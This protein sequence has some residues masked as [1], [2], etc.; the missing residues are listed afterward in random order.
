MSNQQ[1]QIRANVQGSYNNNLSPEAR[2]VMELSAEKLEELL[3]SPI[4]F[5]H[6]VDHLD[7]V[8]NSR[9]LK[10]EW[11]LGNDN[12]SRKFHQDVSFFAR[13]LDFMR[14]PSYRLSFAWSLTTMI[15]L[16]C[17]GRNLAL[18]EVML[19]L[20]KSTAEGHKVAMELQ[21]S[22]EEKLQQ[23]QD[24]LW[25]NGRLNLRARAYTLNLTLWDVPCFFYTGML[26]A[27]LYVCVS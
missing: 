12:V 10:R 1:A 17:L 5:E 4:A 8:V 23:Q 24:A 27:Y 11:W 20:Q 2:I 7:I 6:F 21:K 25:V 18:E 3:E 26:I 19:E 16:W 14:F 15:Y 9:T 22:L 13:W